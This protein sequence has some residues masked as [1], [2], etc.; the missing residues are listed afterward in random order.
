V[1]AEPQSNPY[2]DAFAKGLA[3]FEPEAARPVSMGLLS[4]MGAPMPPPA[5]GWLSNP[6]Q[7]RQRPGMQRAQFGLT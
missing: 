6:L 3:K 4:S 7:Q 1:Q 2:V 5:S